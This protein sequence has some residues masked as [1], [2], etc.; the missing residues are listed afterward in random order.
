MAK[1]ASTDLNDA[2]G[3]K[4]DGFVATKSKVGIVTLIGAHSLST[5]LFV[6][7]TAAFIAM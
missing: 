4:N 5:T 2:Y 7:F 3:F 6:G 1:S